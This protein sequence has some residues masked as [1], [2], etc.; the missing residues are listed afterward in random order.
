MIFR[1]HEGKNEDKKR[2]VLVPLSINF[3]VNKQYIINSNSANV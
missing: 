2:K 3:R 1:Y